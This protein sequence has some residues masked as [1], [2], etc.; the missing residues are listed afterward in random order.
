MAVKKTS[1]G[2]LARMQ[3][4]I[5]KGNQVFIHNMEESINFDWQQIMKAMR[6]CRKRA[7]KKNE[8]LEK[9]KNGYTPE[10]K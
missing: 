6:D 4:T 8:E 3:R 7:I 9:V 10:D 1:G 5:D 2:A